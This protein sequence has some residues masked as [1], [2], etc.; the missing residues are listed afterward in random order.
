MTD[1]VKQNAR[2]LLFVALAVLP[3]LAGCAGFEALFGPA[4][5]PA[6]KGAA[7]A[8]ATV[9]VPAPFNLLVPGVFSLLTALAVP[10]KVPK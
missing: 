9:L 6:A 10:Q 7:L 3:A 1:F 4:A 5:D 8:T 2:G